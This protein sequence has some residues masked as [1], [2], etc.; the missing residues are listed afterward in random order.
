[1]WGRS[2]RACCT[3]YCA[4][5]LRAR[6]SFP[7]L[8]SPCA[9]RACVSLYTPH[10]ASARRTFY[11]PS[12][13]C[14]DSGQILTAIPRFFQ[15]LQRGMISGHLEDTITTSRSTT[16]QNA[17]ALGL[18]LFV[19]LSGL[20]LLTYSGVPLSNDENYLFDNT[21]SFARRGTFRPLSFYDLRPGKD[22]EGNPRI[23]TAQEPMQ[24]ILAALLFR[25]AEWLPEVG[26]MHTVWLFNAF[27]TAL[28]GVALFVVAL[29]QGHAPGKGFTFH[30]FQFFGVGQFHLGHGGLLR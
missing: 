14:Q 15:Y 23:D 2:P 10:Y 19:L 6:A 24:P 9:V 7:L 5:V 1:M 11:L 26:L 28:T 20:Y 17:T 8:A 13:L 30:F 12:S 4:L 27:V 25:V 18:A 21:L 16:R 29:R 3:L 22:V